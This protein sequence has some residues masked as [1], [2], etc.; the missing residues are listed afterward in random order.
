MYSI[1]MCFWVFRIEMCDVVA[2][3]A[4]R[5]LN[6]PWIDTCQKKF[7]TSRQG[8]V[9]DRSHPLMRA[10]F[11]LTLRRAKDY[12]SMCLHQSRKSECIALM[13]IA[14]KEVEVRGPGHG[15]A[16]MPQA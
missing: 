11:G 3:T 13:V 7:Q 5:R 12:A 15:S 2:A 10:G 9:A 4:N 1:G 14:G 16:K 6:Q 8:L